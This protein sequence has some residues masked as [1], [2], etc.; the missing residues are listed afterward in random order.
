MQQE[1]LE[2][3]RGMG[4]PVNNNKVILKG[5]CPFCEDKASFKQIG[6]NLPTSIIKGIMVPIQC[7]GCSSILVYSKE[8]KIFYP[9]PKLKGL[10]ELPE[11]IQKYYDEALRCLSARS[12][13]GAVTI[14]RKIIHALGIHYEIAKK[15][16]NKKLHEIIKGLHDEGHIVK[17]LK[18]AL[19]GIRNIGNDGAHINDNEPDLIQAERIKFLIDTILNSTV[20]SD[21]TLDLVETMHSSKET[22]KK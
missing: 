17:K 4:T 13:N 7:E 2:L 6:H 21:K 8:E 19:L 3:V 22:E 20:L 15:N 9:E 18:D 16:D 11:E 10:K 1:I 12:P 5:T 14:F